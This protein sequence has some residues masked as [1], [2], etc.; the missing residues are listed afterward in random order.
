MAAT[1]SAF[2]SSQS[3][4]SKGAMA[5]RHPQQHEQ[6]QQYQ[7]EAPCLPCARHC[8]PLLI[9]TCQTSALRERK[10]AATELR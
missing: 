4:R 8:Q 1:S 2:S 6:R 5:S 9:N 3:L 10:P 7:R